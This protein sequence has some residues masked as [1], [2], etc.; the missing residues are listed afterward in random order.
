MKAKRLVA[1]G[2]TAAMALGMAA[3][4]GDSGTNTGSGTANAGGGT[5][6]AGSP[7]AGSG[8]I[9]TLKWITIGNGMPTNYDT[10]VEKVNAYA[11]EKI[12]VNV[13]LEVISWGDWDKRRN[14]IVSTN[15]PYDIIFGNGNNYIPDINLGAYYDITDLIEANMPGLCELM[16]DKYWDAVK[17]DGKIYGVPTYKD[18]AISNYSV[19][20]KEL[21]DEYGI[22]IAALTEI[23]DLT[24]IFEQLK[25]DKKDYPVYV[26]NDG[27]YYIFDKY[28]QIGAGTQILGVRYDDT[29][30]KV[31]FTL[32]QDDI[33]AELK[34]FHEWYQK[35]IINPDAATLTEARVYNMWRVAQ[36]WE[37]AAKTVWGPD[38]SKEVVVQKI[39]D[40]I[41]SNETV[42]GSI[43]CISANTQYP[44]KCLQF[45]DLLNKDSKLRD[46]FFYGEE[47]VNFTYN[48]DGTVH[49]INTDFG[50][51]GYTQGTFF[52]VT[53][54]ETDEYGQWDEVKALNDAAVA[55]QMLGFTFDPTGVEDKL[56]N[57]REIWLRYRSEMMTGVLDPETA[58]P[59]IK[60]E[61]M[62]AGFQEILDAAQ[63]QV[64]EF[65]QT[66]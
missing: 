31:C 39:G 5:E 4:C 13:D 10:W 23:P 9:V 41:L 16:P 48:E 28:D 20:D 60:Q 46:M 59:E 58:V 32:E 45:L 26:K 29:D 22:D 52:T 49:R 43:N 42:R 51:P 33:M 30:A 2:L 57:C 53:R 50:L 55:S 21:V 44:E 19:W 1:A 64:D 15:E 61:L 36:G 8:E 38:M 7:S 37:S 34:T 40:T 25:A 63:A 54:E 65:M 14:V 11:G 66:K 56:A 6:D 17:V 35:G 12:G 18:S 62:N 3:G 47:G 27:V 24:P